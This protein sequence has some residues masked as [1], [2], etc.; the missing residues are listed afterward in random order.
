MAFGSPLIWVLRVADYSNCFLTVEGTFRKISKCPYWYRELYHRNS[1]K[2]N[3]ISFVTVPLIIVIWVVSLVRDDVLD[4][5]FFMIGFCWILPSYLPTGKR[6]V[7]TV[8]TAKRY[9]HYVNLI[10]FRFS[11]WTHVHVSFKSDFGNVL[12]VEQLWMFFLK[13]D[14]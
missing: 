4:E 5:G 3:L 11:F 8:R 14:T 12:F 6:T 2:I 13:Y 7:S 9:K 10:F 1:F